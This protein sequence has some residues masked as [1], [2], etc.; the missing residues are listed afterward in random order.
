MYSSVK[1]ACQAV[2]ALHRQ[3][4]GGGGAIWAR[5]LGGEVILS[6]KLH[7][8]MFSLLCSS[9]TNICLDFLSPYLYLTVD[10]SVMCNHLSKK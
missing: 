3:N 8:L 9:N 10:V 5:Q 1:A 4:V 2:A 7:V 6:D